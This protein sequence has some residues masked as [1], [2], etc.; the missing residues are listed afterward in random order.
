MNKKIFSKILIIIIA[1]LLVFKVG[2]LI[3][4]DNS[5]PSEKFD[6][7]PQKNVCVGLSYHYIKIKNPWNLFLDKVTKV[8][9]ITKYSIYK[10]DFEKQINKLIEEKAYFA[11]LDEVKKFR[12]TGVYPDKCVWICFDD[13]EESVYKY[14]YPFLKEKN[15]PFTMF[16]IAG[17]VGNKDFKNLTLSTWD[18]LRE[19]RDSGL[20]TFGSHT[21]DMH[22]LQDNKAKFLNK[23]MFKEFETD[24]K[25]SKK[26]LEDELGIKVTTIAYPFGNASD[27][28]AAIVEKSGFTDGFIL[29]PQPLAKDNDPFYQNRYMLNNEDFYKA[30]VPWLEKNN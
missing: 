23:D 9:E 26:T 20:V 17:Q 16:I 11:T 13:G 29:A 6:E 8:D 22:Y 28:V 3:I 12:Q 27:D 7:I 4:K 30:I 5:A 18:E 14:A 19:M 21:Y 24:V 25:L 2:S 10:D 15:I 1:L